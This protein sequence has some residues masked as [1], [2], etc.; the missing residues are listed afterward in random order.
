MS[1]IRAELKKCREV[2]KGLSKLVTTSTRLIEILK[3]EPVQN[4][5]PI[6]PKSLSTIPSR[7]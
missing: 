4:L 1:E 5:E 2:S 3:L 7:P 6:T